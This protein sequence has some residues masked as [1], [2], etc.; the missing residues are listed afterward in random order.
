MKAKLKYIVL[1][2]VII[3]LMIPLYTNRQA[4]LDQYLQEY[5]QNPDDILTIKYVKGGAYV[6]KDFDED[7]NRAFYFDKGYLGWHYDYDVTYASL[8]PIIDQCGF[9]MAELPNVRSADQDLIFGK[10][11]DPAIQTLR[12]V[13]DTGGGFFEAALVDVQGTQ[14]WYIL[15]EDLKSHD[16]TLNAYDAQGDLVSYVILTPTS[17][18]FPYYRNRDKGLEPMTL[19]R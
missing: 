9:T 1:G 3:L 18:S 2:L 14:L 12:L 19:S 5:F 17:Q 13:N 11:I 8:R 16:L 10:I 7:I 6:F 4:G 15:A